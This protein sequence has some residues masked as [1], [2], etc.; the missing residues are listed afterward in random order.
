LSYVDLMSDIRWSEADHVD[1]VEA[2]VRSSVTHTREHVLT[3]RTF[4]LLFYLLAQSMPAGAQKDL[5]ASLGRPLSPGALA[6]LL[7]AAQAFD[8]ADRLAVD[9]RADSARLDAALDYE[10]ARARLAA[11]SPMPEEGD[12]EDAER[13]AALQALLDA[14][15]ADTLALVAQRDEFREASAPPP[16]EELALE[17]AP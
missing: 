6:E 17:P 11:I 13:R 14:A 8:A 10:D 16:V 5:M 7:S 1:R 3:R 12:D 15:S 2:F 9:A 4:A